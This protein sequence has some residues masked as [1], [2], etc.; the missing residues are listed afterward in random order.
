MLRP[1][2]RL[3]RSEAVA[4]AVHPPMLLTLGTRRM[5]SP[6]REWGASEVPVQQVP[7]LAAFAASISPR[8]QVI[9]RHWDP[10]R[11]SCRIVSLVFRPLSDGSVHEKK[12]R[13]R[14]RYSRG[15]LASLVCS[16]H[17][18]AL[19]CRHAHLH[20]GLLPHPCLSAVA[21]TVCI[22]EMSRLDSERLGD[23]RTR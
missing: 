10:P 22:V 4:R 11:T 13:C 14:R 1:L 16:R 2:S 17:H 23:A 20:A 5:P 12:K 6:W 3:Q 9:H 19:P 15:S 21:C 8:P 7:H 18:A